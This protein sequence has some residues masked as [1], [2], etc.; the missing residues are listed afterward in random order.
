MY[1]KINIILAV[2]VLVFIVS[3]FVGNGGD[4]TVTLNGAATIK[5]ANLTQE[6]KTLLHA[7]GADQ[8]FVFDY[9]LPK[10]NMK[11]L[12]YWIEF[13]KNGKDQGKQLGGSSSIE[14]SRDGKLIVTIRSLDRKKKH[15]AQ[16]VMTVAEKNGYTQ[17][18]G[19]WHAA[20]LKGTSM[21]G[22]NQLSKIKSGKP[23]TLA[24]NVRDPYASSMEMTTGIFHNSS[25]L[26]KWVGE[27]KYVYVL[28]CE[29]GKNSEGM[30]NH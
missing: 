10:Q 24:V 28:R 15:S 29:F 18:T 19:T 11:S 1:K 13:Y 20:I 12:H 6:E 21:T 8:V 26:K 5:P 9:H 14:G 3:E 2:V 16:W 25:A 27:Y 17:T 30:P 7:G 23:I 22:E 4:R